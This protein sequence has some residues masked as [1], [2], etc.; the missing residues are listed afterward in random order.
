MVERVG[1]TAA[2]TENV[3]MELM[4]LV[5]KLAL[6]GLDRP[7]GFS[8]NDPMCGKLQSLSEVG[9]VLP[10]VMKGARRGEGAGVCGRCKAACY[11]SKLCRRCHKDKHCAICRPALAEAAAGA[12]AGGGGRRTS[13]ANGRT[14]KK[15]SR[16]KS[17]SRHRTS[18]GWEL[19]SA[20]GRRNS[21]K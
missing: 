11:S 9:L 5:S 8:C 2:V 15:C 4:S 7:V 19:E 6:T 1:P 17:S 16:H 21:V 20:R 3:A 12:A 10:G 13:T 18:R 14:A